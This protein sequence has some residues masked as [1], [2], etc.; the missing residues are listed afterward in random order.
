MDMSSL[1][2]TIID[3]A[4]V[5]ITALAGTG[6]VYFKSYI[7]KRIENEELKNS[8]LLSMTTLENSVKSSIQNLSVE[9]KK[10]L[11]DG[12]VSKEEL[13]NIK[14]SAIEHFEKQV[15]PALQKRLV[16]HVGDMETFI[17]NKISAE[18]QKAD[19]V[20]G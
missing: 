8:I 18:L 9:G 7:N 16:A 20:T 17:T 4:A 19:K 2:Q 3:S 11:A 1:Y 14:K 6:V 12:I 13:N 5:I 15:S 10:A